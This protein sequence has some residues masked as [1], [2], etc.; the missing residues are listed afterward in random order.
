MSY[1]LSPVDVAATII[2]GLANDYAVIECNM[3]YVIE[4]KT[5]CVVIIWVLH[6]LF[7]ISRSLLVIICSALWLPLPNV[8][9]YLQMNIQVLMQSMRKKRRSELHCFL[10]FD[11]SN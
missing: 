9:V 3:A 6:L 4:W 11:N 7:N 2:D 10:Y 1:K 5:N 8:M